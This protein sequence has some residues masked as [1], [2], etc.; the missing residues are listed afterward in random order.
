M[1]S[2]SLDSVVQPRIATWDLLLGLGFVVDPAVLSDS[3]PGLSYDFGILKLEASHVLNQ[4]HIPIVLLGGL[5]RTARTFGMIESAMPVEVESAE[6]GMAWLAWTLDG[7]SGPAT[8][9][10]PKVP[11]WLD[12]GRQH[13]GLLPW[14]RE[15]AAYEARPQ[16]SVRRE[17]AKLAL[18]SLG[19]EL[20]RLEDSV[21]VT[22]RFDG[23]VLALSCGEG[24][25]PMPACGTAW[26]HGYAIPVKRLRRLPKRLRFDPVPVSVWESG[27][28][29]GNWRYE[30]VVCVDQDS[31]T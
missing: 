27:I 14:E 3:K 12:K 13:F 25:I 29:I 22:F 1:K 19:A 11:W 6:E 20:A 10:P 31:E 5:V 16:C 2:E 28:T 9:E 17:W 30:G 15:R 21:L 26:T 18:K 4:Y 8:F 24:T 23:S 7:G